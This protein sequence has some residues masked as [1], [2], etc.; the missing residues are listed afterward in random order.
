MNWKILFN[1]FEKYSETTLLIFGIVATL[2]GSFL[3]YLMN[4]CFDGIIDM[5][6]VGN[7]RWYQPFL[8]N[9]INIIIL[10]S[11]LILLGKALNRKTRFIDILA[12][13]LIS[14]IPIYLSSLSNIGGFLYS[15]SEKVVESFVNNGGTS[16]IEI[17]D[18]IIVTIIGVI[19]IPFIIWMI[20]LLWKGFKTATNNKTIK[21]VLFFIKVVIASE[22]L[23]KLLITEFNV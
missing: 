20:V 4:A 23:S 2:L 22:L 6:L 12:V 11:F 21:G 16:Q 19:V 5:H 14:R 8:D 9:L 13:V 10:T 18:L 7:I 3:G 17:K 15:H 1:P